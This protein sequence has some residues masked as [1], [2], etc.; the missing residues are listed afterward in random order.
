MIKTGEIIGT[1][2]MRNFIKKKT[3]CT[4]LSITVTT[5]LLIGCGKKDS[6]VDNQSDWNVK[7]EKSTDETSEESVAKKMIIEPDSEIEVSG[8]MLKYTYVVEDENGG[9][10]AL[11]SYD[12]VDYESPNSSEWQCSS[13]V[14][15]YGEGEFKVFY[16]MA[17]SN[18][19]GSTQYITHTPNGEFLDLGVSGA[20]I[21]NID[22]IDIQNNTVT[23]DTRIDLFGTH[24]I[25]PVYIIGDQGLEYRDEIISFNNE[26]V[27]SDGSYLDDYPEELSA[28]YDANGRS[29][30]TLKCDLELKT[31]DGKIINMAAGS[32]LYIVGYAPMTNRF[33]VEVAGE[34]AYFEYEEKQGE[35][36]WGHTINGMDED[37]VFEY[38]LYVG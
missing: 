11:F 36:E 25:R 12:G 14:I 6:T 15:D 31:D 17:F 19:W 3:V 7:I 32:Q 35:Y 8:K 33:Y 24:G 10:H 23:L 26:A 9:G 34:T 5:A 22:D 29:L 28:V 13:Y 27:V 30:L 16:E 20:G 2:I 1:E 4:L 38:L 21:V 18:D 37:D